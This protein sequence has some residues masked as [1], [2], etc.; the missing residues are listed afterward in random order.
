ME[1]TRIARYED[2]RAWLEHERGAHEEA[3]GHEINP[4]EPR[5]AGGLFAC[6][7]S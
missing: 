3:H 1:E 7:A 6:I 4:Y 5:K 2:V